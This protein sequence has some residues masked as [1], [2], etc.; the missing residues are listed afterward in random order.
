MATD[1]LSGQA[2]ATAMGVARQTI[3]TWKADGC[4]FQPDRKSG[5]PTYMVAEVVP[6]L[7]QRERDSVAP[8]DK[9]AEQARKLKAEADRVELEVAKLRDELLPVSAFE[10]AIAAEHDEMRAAWMS[11]PSSFARLVVDRTGCTMA[12]AQS[13]LAEIA[14]RRMA[15]LQGSGDDDDGG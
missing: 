2:L 1:R 5:A 15:E 12:V 9:E 14:D 3:S 10:S 7:L 4:P 11:L 8:A 6:W 13:V